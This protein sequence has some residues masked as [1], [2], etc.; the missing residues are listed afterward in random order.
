[1]MRD[2]ALQADR[3]KQ[4]AL[5]WRADDFDAAVSVAFKGCVFRRRPDRLVVVQKTA[6]ATDFQGE[7]EIRAGRG[8]AGAGRKQGRLRDGDFGMMDVRKVQA[9]KNW[10][11]G[12]QEQ[13]NFYRRSKKFPA[14]IN[15]KDCPAPRGADENQNGNRADGAMARREQL[16]AVINHR[17]RQAEPEEDEPQLAAVCA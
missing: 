5:H 14:E 8:C 2:F 12:L 16:K 7:G 13:N 15:L 11:Q 9:D 17:Q 6:T 10:N 3:K 1:M 4:V